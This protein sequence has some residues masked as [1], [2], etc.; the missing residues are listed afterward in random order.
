MLMSRGVEYTAGLLA[1]DAHSVFRRVGEPESTAQQV[2]SPIVQRLVSTTRTWTTAYRSGIWRGV[3]RATRS[4]RSDDIIRRG[5]T[6]CLPWNR[7][8]HTQR[9]VD[10]HR[11]AP[12]RRAQRSIA[13]VNRRF[14]RFSAGMCG[15]GRQL[16]WSSTSRRGRHDFGQPQQ[17]PSRPCALAG[18]GAARWGPGRS[19]SLGTCRVDDVCRRS[20]AHGCL[21]GRLSAPGDDPLV[22]A[23]GPGSARRRDSDS[24]RLAAGDAEQHDHRPRQDWQ[25]RWIQSRRAQRPEW[26]A[27]LVSDHRL[28]PAVAQLDAELLAGVDAGQSTV[29]RRRGRHGLFPGQRRLERLDRGPAGV[30]WHGQLSS[31]PG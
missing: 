27:P 6:R 8:V 10:S 30:L 16:T 5:G 23:R 7:T 24:L 9:V 20:T 21:G 2:Q 3:V 31:E 11:V 4:S 1:P 13:R 28:R 19:G 26:C 22:H 15:D 14:I 18:S 29:L 17:K 25:H 12:R